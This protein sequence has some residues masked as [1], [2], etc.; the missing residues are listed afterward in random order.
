MPRSSSARTDADTKD[1][2][3]NPRSKIAGRSVVTAAELYADPNVPLA[4]RFD[5]LAGEPAGA[6]LAATHLAMQIANDCR[7]VAALPLGTPP[8]GRF[9]TR[10]AEVRALRMAHEKCEKVISSPEFG[11]ILALLNEHPIEVFD[12]PI[13]QAIRQQFAEQGSAAAI[14]VAL[15][16]LRARPDPV[17]AHVVADELAQL[18][19][20]EFL[21]LEGQFQSAI[22]M[23][24]ASRQQVIR[25][26][27]I[28]LTC[29][30]GRP[31][32]PKS[33]AVLTACF[34]MGICIPGADL[35]I[36]YK[37]EFTSSQEWRDVSALL[38]YLRQVQPTQVTRWQ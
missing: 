21:D 11:R 23:N 16:A 36:L 35:H 1:L 25:D 5:A 4:Q 33:L 9:E 19:V 28:L 3:G 7:S 20:G 10:P 24:P 12:V 37:Q 26:A 22:N 8:I 18:G 6:G 32:G 2:A 14:D 15:S 31:C 27:M 29:D 38:D 17:T 13:E 30:Y 34:G